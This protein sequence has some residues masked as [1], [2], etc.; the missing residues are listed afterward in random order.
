MNYYINM[1]YKK[2][3]LWKLYQKNKINIKTENEIL[4]NNVNIFQFL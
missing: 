3:N 1:I 4:L 2:I